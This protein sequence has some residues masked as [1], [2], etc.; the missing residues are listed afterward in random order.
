MGSGKVVY[1]DVRAGLM[2]NGEVHPE[3]I[4]YIARIGADWYA[5]PDAGSMFE[6]PATSADRNAVA[7]RPSIFRYK[8]KLAF[9]E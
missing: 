7:L 5:R 4:E 6:L 1:F 2:D 9:W 8:L 3:R